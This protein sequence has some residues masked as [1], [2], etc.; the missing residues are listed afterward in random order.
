MKKFQL[1]LYF[2]CLILLFDIVKAKEV[3]INESLPKIENL[4]SISEMSSIGFEWDPLYDQNIAG[5]YLYRASDSEPN[6]KIVATIKDKFQTHFVDT[7]LDPNTK[8]F[9]SLRSFNDQGHISEEGKVIEVYTMPRLEKIPFAEAITNL[10]NRI[11]LIW[12]PHP[13][14]RVNSYIIERMKEGEGEFKKIAEVKNRLNAEY[15]D[16]NLKPNE[17][18]T[19]RIFALSFDGVKSEPSNI[20]NSNS[21]AL[22]PEVTSLNASFDQ[23]NKILLNWDKSD[24]KDF[25]YYKIYSTS[26]S[27]LPYTLLAKTQ[28][29]NYEDIVNGKNKSKYYKVTIVDKDGLE[30]PMPKN[31]IEGKTLGD[32][33][34]PSIILAQ[35]KD[36]AI[37]VEW[38]DNDN[39]AV[40]YMVKRY[41]G[42]STAIF[43]GLKEKKLRDIKALPGVEYTYEVIS[44]DNQG[45]ESE[46]SKKVKAAQ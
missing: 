6:F 17:N 31:A 27:F 46:P 45:L 20:L 15:I 21:K 24:Y 29:N 9:Y 30:S 34:A 36:G 43:K 41:G 38:I 10:P 33:L 26:S 8:Y 16:D 42:G 3:L 19:Y 37:E 44:I 7:K 25:S 4:K 14:L 35:I 22:P 28:D 13:D 2:L 12:R 5:F 1:K 11:K 40:E 39:R 32:P 23:V 18:F